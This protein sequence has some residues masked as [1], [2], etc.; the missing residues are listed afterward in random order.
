MAACLERES[1]GTQCGALELDHHFHLFPPVELKSMFRAA[2]LDCTSQDQPTRMLQDHA[3]SETALKILEFS[4]YKEALSPGW[5]GFRQ[6]GFSATN[7]VF[8]K[9]MNMAF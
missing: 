9:S 3:V 4:V 5:R 8:H 1:C 6:P 2:K 7:V